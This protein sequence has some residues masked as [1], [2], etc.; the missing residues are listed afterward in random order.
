MQEPTPDEVVDAVM[1]A[2]RALVAVAARSLAA[3]EEDV[4]LPQYRAL[5]V[6][7]QH[8]ARRPADLAGA[9]DVS[10]SSATRM[11]DR[12]VAK[13]LIERDR[14]GE[15]RREVRVALS[16]RGR[17]LVEEVT[18]RRRAEL[19]TLLGG[20]PAESRTAVVEALRTFAAAA[21]EVPEPEWAM[22]P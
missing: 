19:A 5:I 20:L 10:P 1:S 15:D 6:L 17:A 7:A 16:E 11:C 21:G 9:L 14:T 13:G 3:V 2:S 22:L 4:T 8:G 12:L 18:R